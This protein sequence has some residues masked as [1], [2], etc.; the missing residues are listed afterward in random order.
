MLWLKCTCIEIALFSTSSIPI[1]TSVLHS[2]FFAA[3][4]VAMLST[5]R[6]KLP[7]FSDVETKRIDTLC[8]QDMRDAGFTDQQLDGANDYTMAIYKN[9]VKGQRALVELSES[10][11][12]CCNLLKY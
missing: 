3:S 7:T 11:L 8:H 1:F 4:H 6:D 2:K 12:S 9:Q 5:M 10:I